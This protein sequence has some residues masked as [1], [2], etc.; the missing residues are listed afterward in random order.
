MERNGTWSV[1]L[2]TVLYI[3]LIHQRVSNGIMETPRY[4]L[5]I[6]NTFNG[7]GIKIKGAKE[8]KQVKKYK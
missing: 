2:S 5:T 4:M 7:C 8:W 1:C 6:E 3:M